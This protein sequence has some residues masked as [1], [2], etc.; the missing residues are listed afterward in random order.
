MSTTPIRHA[1]SAVRAAELQRHEPQ[2]HHHRQPGHAPTSRGQFGGYVFRLGRAPAPPAPRRTVPLSQRRPAPGAQQAGMETDSEHA[3]QTGVPLQASALED[4]Q[5]AASLGIDEAT[6]HDDREG[7]EGQDRR[8]GHQALQWRVRAQAGPAAE[9]SAMQA[10]LKEAC[11]AGAQALWQEPGAKAQGPSAEQARALVSALLA[12][13]SPAG[14]APSAPRPGVATLQ[15]AAVRS[16]LQ[17]CSEPGALATLAH[18]KQALLDVLS[19]GTPNER[20]AMPASE[21]QQNRNLL[22]PLLLLNADKPRT[23][24]LRH[25]ACDRIEL[26]C[27][28]GAKGQ[29]R[30]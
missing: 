8:Q 27:L 29:G 25:R 4:E 10:W 1:T 5:R 15:L 23:D 3:L 2:Q 20:T 12:I 16:Y 17:R 22:L 26:L 28:P 14:L 9:A 7:T 30:P 24:R 6:D 11:G 19:T 21:P 18:V 13:N